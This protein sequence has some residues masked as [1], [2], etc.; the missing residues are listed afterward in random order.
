MNELKNSDISNRKP[1]M[2]NGITYDLKLARERLLKPR[3]QVRKNM[4][5][6]EW[7]LVAQEI[8]VYFGE[9]YSYWVRNLPKLSHQIIRESFEW[10]KS[11]PY[12]K[13]N[14]AKILMSRFT[15][16]GGEDE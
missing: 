1:D 2:T 9:G 14:Q 16:G 12:P 8:S 6:S 7:H 4:P 15:K 13:K 5:A 3:K 11:L 10:A